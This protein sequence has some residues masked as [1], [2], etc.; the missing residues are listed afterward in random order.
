[1]NKRQKKKAERIKC[2]RHRVRD[3]RTGKW[4]AVYSPI[5]HMVRIGELNRNGML[6]HQPY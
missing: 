5:C 1:M 2:H 4:R 6:Y 3:P